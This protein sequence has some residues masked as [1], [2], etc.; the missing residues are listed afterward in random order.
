[1]N[2]ITNT[3]I[4]EAEEQR[5]ALWSAYTIVHDYMHDVKPWNKDTLKRTIT[6]FHIYENEK[7]AK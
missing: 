5:L 7:T 3:A 1:M 6:T 4:W 2:N